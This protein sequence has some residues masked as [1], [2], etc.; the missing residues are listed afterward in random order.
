MKPNDVLLKSKLQSHSQELQE[1]G[2]KIGKLYTDHGMPIDMAL[3]RLD[4]SHA[5]KVSILDGACQWI[6]QHKRDS[7]ATQK[8]IERT[9]QSNRNMMERFI[10]GQETGAY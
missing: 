9:R 7:G 4:Y 3:D 1:L 5:Q 8:A 6:V 10:A 2:I